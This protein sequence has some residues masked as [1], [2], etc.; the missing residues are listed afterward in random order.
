MY[1]LIKKINKKYLKTA[2]NAV[3]THN[4]QILATSI[5][6][7]NIE[8]KYVIIQVIKWIDILVRN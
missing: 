5:K 4:V 6:M 1:I 8:F 2:L 7:C 3:K